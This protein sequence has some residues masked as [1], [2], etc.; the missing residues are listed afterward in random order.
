LFAR[1]R[2][3][4][5]SR[6]RLDEL[7]RDRKRT[8]A[9]LAE[10][11]KRR[12]DAR[13]ALSSI[14]E[15]AAAAALSL[16]IDGAVGLEGLRRALDELEL[17]R[18]LEE[19]IGEHQ[20]AIEEQ[21]GEIETFEDALT[22]LEAGLGLDG[23]GDLTFRVQRV[24]EHFDA[25]SSA[26]REREH[27]KEVIGRADRQLQSAFGTNER[28]QTLMSE[29]ALGATEVWRAEQQRLGEALPVAAERVDLELGAVRDVT[30]AAEALRASAEVAELATERES[31]GA[32]LESVLEQW[33]ALGVAKS[34]LEECLARY[35]RD[36]Q[37]KVVNYASS[38]FCEI[39]EGRY[40]RLAV[41]GDDGRDASIAALDRSGQLVDATNL[42]TGA[43]EQLYLTL[44]LA[45]AATFA[46]ESATL[47]IVVDDVTANA[48]DDREAT[49]ATIL[50][51]VAEQHQVIAFTCH[52][53][54]VETL[55]NASPGARVIEL[56]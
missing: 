17:A 7:E 43:K 56:G 52:P 55:L 15:R 22:D 21:R 54:L 45:F 50:A 35:R 20:K 32:A 48:D 37:P 49:V 6:R 36:R 28:A 39:T 10:A 12:D 47:P 16:G 1:L 11:T 25:A 13:A 33:L 44:R 46:E 3:E 26:E 24:A 42:S 53:S 40:T 34:L 5:E 9:G 14:D 29:L 27:L 31:T 38:L 51:R 19:R 41:T 23:L 30:R 2:E 4:R 18:S 8:S